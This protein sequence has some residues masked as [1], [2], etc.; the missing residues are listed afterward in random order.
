MRR[1]FPALSVRCHELVSIANS[2]LAGQ[3]RAPRRN[4]AEDQEHPVRDLLARDPMGIRG[5]QP[6]LRSRRHAWSPRRL[7]WRAA[8]QQNLHQSRDS[9]ARC[10]ASNSRTVAP[11]RS[12]DGAR[13]CRD[14]VEGLRVSRVEVEEC[15][16]GHKHPSIRICFRGRRIEGYQEQKQRSTPRSTGSECASSLARAHTLSLGR[17]LDLCQSALSWQDPVYISNPFPTS[18]ST[19]NRARLKPQ[20]QQASADWVST[21]LARRFALSISREISPAAPS[22][23]PSCVLS[24]GRRKPLVRRA[25]RL[26]WGWCD[27]V[28]IVRPSHSR[29]S[30]SA[31]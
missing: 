3:D 5:T 31:M 20:E 26:S 6:S 19:C 23:Q 14:G 15:R 11:A 4:Q 28:A 27:E 21:Q 8:E 13:R 18:H 29:R 2:R 30:R 1:L 7:N 25:P 16:L 12:N 9:A 10:R 22:G 24:A 17:R